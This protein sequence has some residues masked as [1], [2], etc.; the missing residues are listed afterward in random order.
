[1]FITALGLPITITWLVTLFAGLFFVKQKPQFKRWL[2]GV[3]IAIPALTIV[4]GF[5]FQ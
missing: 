1:L 4:L 3:L 5:L 2:I